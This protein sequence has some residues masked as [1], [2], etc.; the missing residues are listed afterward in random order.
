MASSGRPERVYHQDYIARIRYSNAL[1][2]PPCPPKLLEIPN[3]GVVSGGYTS[4]KFATRLAR[5]QPVN[6]EADAELGMPIDLVGLPGVF[7]GDESFLMASDK[8]PYIDPRDKAL[9]KPL[10][11][12][13]KPTS[14]TQGVSFLRRMEYITGSSSNSGYRPSDSG[15]LR[16][17]Q[18]PKR[19]KHVTDAEKELPINNIRC[20]MKGFDIAYPEDAYR[21]TQDTLENV[22]AE[23]ITHAER[24][25]WDKP[26]HPTKSN[27]KLLD[28]YPLLPD[29]DAAPEG[30]SFVLTRFHGNPMPPS[31][32]YDDRI[33]AGILRILPPDAEIQARLAA[34]QAAA[35]NDPELE[36]PLGEYDYEFFLPNSHETVR[37]IKRKFSVTD[38]DADS[39]DLYDYRNDEGQGRFKYERVRAYETYQQ[40]G[41]PRDPYGGEVALALHDPEMDVG[42]VPGTKKRLEKAAYY[43]PI[44]QRTFI[45]PRRSN[46]KMTYQQKQE[47]EE[48]KI[49][50]LELEVRQPNEDEL[51]V[52]NET[53]AKYE[54][55]GPEDKVEPETEVVEQEDG[56]QD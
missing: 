38:P 26:K 34:E 25:A 23:P 43:Y 32:Q 19:R 14:L 35:E 47:Q 22:V 31:S 21:G 40:S 8:Q 2:P 29:L 46:K 12:L 5:E 41:R 4:A 45:R 52:R 55:D 9:L 16:S 44:M 20:I 27:V 6:I 42:A 13:G 30:G 28:T 51:A 36:P 10:S 7:D 15:A 48:Q 54:P 11:A 33:E 24:E 39:P 56:Q 18:N 17:K 53:R 50:V 49:D 1:P 3:T 37:G